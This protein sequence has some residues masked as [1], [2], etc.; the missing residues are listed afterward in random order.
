MKRN[1]AVPAN[2]LFLESDSLM[3]HHDRPAFYRSREGVIGRKG[4]THAQRFVMFPGRSRH[5]IATDGGQSF[6][7]PAQ[8][9]PM[10]WR[11]WKSS[12]IIYHYSAD[13]DFPLLASNRFVLP[14]IFLLDHHATDIWFSD[15]RQSQA[16]CELREW[17]CWA[18]EH[19]QMRCECVIN[20]SR[21]TKKKPKSDEN[22]ADGSPWDLRIPS[23]DIFL[24][25][26]CNRIIKQGKINYSHFLNI[27]IEYP[28]AARRR[29]ISLGAPANELWFISRRFPSLLSHR[30]KN[31]VEF[32]R[33]EMTRER[34]NILTT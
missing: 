26:A 20:P 25:A 11:A 21:R 33:R 1:R 30:E 10:R 18:L 9:R 14:K 3:I 31:F 23:L 2:N 32:P 28:R 13:C 19:R 17:N 5:V 12:K 4:W 7:M 29:A 22:D 6:V 27:L 15:R 16:V 34:E 24:P 8:P